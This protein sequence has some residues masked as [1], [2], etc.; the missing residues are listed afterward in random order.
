MTR[1]RRDCAHGSGCSLGEDIIVVAGAARDQSPP[2]DGRASIARASTMTLPTH[3]DAA[4]W[5]PDASKVF[6]VHVPFGAWM[7]S[8][9]LWPAAS[10]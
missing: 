5:R 2:T 10:Q 3:V 6:Q 1:G 9:S 8:Q 7:R 4:V